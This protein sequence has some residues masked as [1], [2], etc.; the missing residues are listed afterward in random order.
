MFSVLRCAALNSSLQLETLA[1]SPSPELASKPIVSASVS[2]TLL[3]AS[4]LVAA[5]VLVLLMG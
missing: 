2:R 5:E 4:P 1:P 3:A